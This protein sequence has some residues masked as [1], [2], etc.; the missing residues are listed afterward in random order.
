MLLRMAVIFISSLEGTNEEIAYKNLLE[1]VL[2]GSC[3]L[4]C[5]I[6]V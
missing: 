2:P 4:Q 1:E 3:H 5:L 6:V